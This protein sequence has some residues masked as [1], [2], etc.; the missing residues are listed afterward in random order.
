MKLRFRGNS[1]RLRVNQKEVESLAEGGQVFE[2]I[3]F[4]NG[5]TLSYVLTSA[6]DG[7]I[8]TADFDGK[9]IRV[10]AALRQWCRSSEIGFYFNVEPSLKVSVE[11]DLECMDGP[12]D[13][14]DPHA[15][16]RKATG[17]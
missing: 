11:K 17:C 16:P 15:F 3:A 6:L 4:G 5:A 7:T 14:K 12:E 8:P 1:L 9:T 10:V 2:S 13:E